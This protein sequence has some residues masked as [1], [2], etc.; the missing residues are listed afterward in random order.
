MQNNDIEIH[1]THNEAKSIV[2]ER[3]IRTLKKKIYKSM[4]SILKNVYFDKLDDIVNKYNNTHHSTIKM[5]PDDVKSSTYIDSSK[6]INDKDPEFKIGDVAR[7]SKYKNI[8]AKV[9][10]PN[11]AEEVFVIKNAVLKILNFCVKNT[12]LWTYVINDLNRDKIVGTFYEKESQKTNQKVFRVEKVI[13]RKGE[14]L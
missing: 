6:E 2:G 11:W 7:I 3:F 14:R 5:K 13:K 4:T 9:Y 8:F 1:L 12:V 10:T